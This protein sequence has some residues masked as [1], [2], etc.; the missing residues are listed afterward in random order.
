MLA[1][2]LF[3]V[4]VGCAAIWFVVRSFMAVSDQATGVIEQVPGSPDK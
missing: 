2:K 4:L 3:V 1:V